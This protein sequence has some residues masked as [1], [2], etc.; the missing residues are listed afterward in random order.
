MNAKQKREVVAALLKAG[1]RDLARQFVGAAAVDLGN[2]LKSMRESW[3]RN[4]SGA[5]FYFKWK[6]NPFEILLIEREDIV[7]KN[8]V[9]QPERTLHLSSFPTGVKK[10][11]PPKE[12][13]EQARQYV[14]KRVGW[15]NIKASVVTAADGQAIGY[16]MTAMA[17]AE[18]AVAE[19]VKQTTTAI[20]QNSD[21]M[22]RDQG[23]FPELGK[24]KQYA[25]EARDWLRK[26]K[27]SL[28]IA[29]RRTS[30]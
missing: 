3:N 15:Q 22:S 4:N 5:T 10:K 26:A 19:A 24:A 11:A 23:V 8:G 17:T 16:A 30:P 12:V 1:R 2:D 27:K 6:N 7:T 9:T 13:V 20:A 28:Q 29:A 14:L 18:T 21:P 25:N